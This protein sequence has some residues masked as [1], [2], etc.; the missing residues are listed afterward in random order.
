MSIRELRIA[1]TFTWFQLCPLFTW[2][3]TLCA[4]NWF[5]YIILGMNFEEWILL[6]A[7]K[8]I[9]LAHGS[10]SILWHCV[11]GVH[12]RSFS[13]PHFNAFWPNTE[14]YSVSLLIQSECGKNSEQGH[15]SRIVKY[16]VNWCYNTVPTTILLELSIKYTRAKILFKETIENDKKSSK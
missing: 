16:S 15:F 9:Y 5:K 4:R 6:S 11:K 10:R 8:T 1:G 13:G 2:E 12:I 14:S 3:F 7:C